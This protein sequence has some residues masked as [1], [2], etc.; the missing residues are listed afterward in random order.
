VLGVWLSAETLWLL[1]VG[2]SGDCC[3]IAYGSLAAGS[4]HI[5]NSAVWL[6]SLIVFSVVL[7][8]SALFVLCTKGLSQRLITLTG[9]CGIGWCLPASVCLLYYFSAYY[10][11]V[12]QHSCFWCL[13][14]PGNYCVGYPLFAAMGI[15]LSQS[16]A[17]LLYGRLSFLKPQLLEWTREKIR[18]NAMLLIVGTLIYF[19]LTIGPAGIF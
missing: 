6:F 10:Y 7:F 17:I 1:N 3:S 9:C 2:A 12:S 15:I 4:N 14:L 11:G 8:L 13:F 19:L 18:K 16:V 5:F